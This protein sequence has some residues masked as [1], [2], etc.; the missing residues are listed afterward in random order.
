M[1][2]SDLINEFKSFLKDRTKILGFNSFIDNYLPSDDM[3]KIFG[4]SEE[5]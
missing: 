4:D 5:E 2:V 3:N 1:L